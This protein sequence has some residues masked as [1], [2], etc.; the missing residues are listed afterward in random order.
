MPSANGRPTLNEV[1]RRIE[2]VER[3][4]ESDHFIP[5]A[6]FDARTKNLADKLD[7]LDRKLEE[8]TDEQRWA[9]RLLITAFVGIL[10]NGAVLAIRI[11]GMG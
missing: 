2:R 6:L 10:V 5:A 8:L 9:R 7:S 4:V 1:T 3:L 11:S